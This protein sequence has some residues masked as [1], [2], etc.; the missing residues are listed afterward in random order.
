MKKLWLA[1]SIL[2]VTLPFAPSPAPGA[3]SGPAQGE[4]PTFADDVAPIVFTNCAPCHRPGEA[5]PF[6]LLSYEDVRQRGRFIAAVTG[7]RYMPPWHADS[8]MG[9]FR[10]DRRLNEDEIRII[11]DWV[12]A[13][14]PE[15]EPAR[16]PAPPQF[17]PGWQ[18]GEPDLVVRMAE[19]FQIPEDGPDLFRNFAI[20][21]DVAEDRW[22]SA[23]EFRPS[24]NA[25]HHAL[26]F[27]DQTGGAL[28]MDAEDPGP[29][30]DGMDFLG[31]S[32]GG[33][34]GR[35]LLQALLG[36]G[37]AGR[38]RGG[39]GTTATVSALGGW[40]VGG[41]PAELPEGTARRLPAGSD[42]V[43]Q[44]HF[45]PTGRPETEQ[46][47][48]GIYFADGAPRR[49]LV[50]LQMPPL[51][52]AFAGIDIPA[53]ESR[54][55]ISDS[56]TLPI[57]VEVLGGGAHAH[58]LST[59]MTMTAT[60]PDGA[61]HDLLAIPDWDFNWQERYY[62]TDPIRLPSGT[63][64]DVEIAYDNTAD[65]PVNPFDP[66]QRV[67]FGR[68]STD[69][70]GSMTLEFLAVRERDLL[71]YAEAYRAYVQ[72]AVL[73]GLIELGRGRLGAR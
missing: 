7:S 24:G 36:R 50:P 63:R 18:L 40:A 12:A 55:V 8:E 42:L 41:S 45:H 10:D 70:M 49:T 28:R 27:L 62:F 48:V 25:S 61:V 54:Y 21:L 20:P 43:L 30:F 34:G 16:T 3:A 32:A 1:P 38:G 6:T 59:D 4:S 60:L 33:G 2:F 14:M 67:T 44:M 65:N 71:V 51:F 15:G 47:R 5:T 53:G 19:P 23:V 22:V 13:G 35:G 58:Y 72:D 64:I 68:E 9:E 39:T 11:Q 37:G 29:G 46:A 56:F 69:E 66:P 17:T 31:D 73:N 52:G 26:F 57:D